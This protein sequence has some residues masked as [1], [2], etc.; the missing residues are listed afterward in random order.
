[1]KTFFIPCT[2]LLFMLFSGCNKNPQS[3]QKDQKQQISDINAKLSI[4]DRELL[5]LCSDSVLRTDEVVEKIKEKKMNVL[6]AND[7]L[8]VSEM[9]KDGPVFI[10]PLFSKPPSSIDTQAIIETEEALPKSLETSNSPEGEKVYLLAAL[11]GKG[12]EDWTG[13]ISKIF[14]KQNRGYTIDRSMATL[15]KLASVS[16][17]SIVLIYS[18][19]NNFGSSH[20][21]SRSS[22]MQELTYCVSS[23]D[24]PTNELSSKYFEDIHDRAILFSW[25]RVSVNSRWE[26]FVSGS[27]GE[28]KWHY[29]ITGLFVE[30]YWSFSQ[31]GMAFLACCY[32]GQGHNEFHQAI[33]NKNGTIITGFTGPTTPET[34]QKCANY[35]FDRLLGANVYKPQTTL[36][37]PFSFTETY[38]VMK[39]KGIT[40]QTKPNKSNCVYFSGTG[41][42]MKFLA[43]SIKKVTPDDQK[44]ELIIEGMFGDKNST[45]KVTIGQNSK[46]IKSWSDTEIR[47]QLGLEDYG[48]VVV[49]THKHKSNPVPLTSWKGVMTY[50][51]KM[52]EQVFNQARINFHLRADVHRYRE[53]PDEAPETG[54]R[55][56]R[57]SR[58]SSCEYDLATTMYTPQMTYDYA[59]GSLAS[60]YMQSSMTERFAMW[61]SVDLASK[62]NLNLYICCSV[63][64]S[65]LCFK[66]VDEQ[67]LKIDP[68]IQIPV[69]IDIQGSDVVVNSP[70]SDPAPDKNNTFPVNYEIKFDDK[71]NII[72]GSTGQLPIA[73]DGAST[74]E[75]SWET[76]SARGAPTSKTAE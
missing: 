17:A 61:G 63:Y 72:A 15:D 22:V 55:E 27:A 53:K 7:S 44:Q 46:T 45:S 62:T 20:I 36:Q 16:D 4:M 68:G 51:V 42:N 3:L 58:S 43:P 2:V 34:V 11:D 39:S 21:P 13:D 67:G 29:A 23:S 8:V 47:C 5:S 76:I 18:H 32:S 10:V 64:K 57:L 69:V 70:I 31:K 48:D 40:A 14:A 49:E 65:G 28:Q 59:S 71:F 50:T 30:K 75:L 12:F 6:F 66:I 26:A 35:L 38:D 25:D 9:Y 73:S 41:D 56:L 1:M 37:R 52:G 33:Y 74:A 19:G 54:V 60:P 24:E